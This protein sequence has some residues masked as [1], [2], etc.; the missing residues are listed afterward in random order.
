MILVAYRHGLCG[1]CKPLLQPSYCSNSP[2]R[3]ITMIEE[4]STNARVRGRPK[5]TTKVPYD[6]LMTIW[7]QVEAIREEIKSRTGYRPSV[8]QAC[9]LVERRGGLWWLVGGNVDAIAR[10]MASNRGAPFSDW[11]RFRMAPQGK[12]D[13]LIKDERN[14][15]VV[16]SHALQHANTLRTR[17]TE[18]NRLFR[19]DPYVREAWENMLCDRLGRPRPPRDPAL[20]WR[21]S[22]WRM[23]SN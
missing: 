10:E 1:L 9:K 11:R 21:P 19:A 23:P 12:A 16:V 8:L 7:L 3:I 22:P 14:G 18:A 6:Y 13:R 4:G 15:R 5:G 17:Y 2:I 20:I